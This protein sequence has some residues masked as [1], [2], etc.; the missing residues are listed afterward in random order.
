MP[1]L[2]E[3]E[4]TCR[5]IAPHITGKRVTRVI[6]RNPNLRWPVSSRLGK[7]LS[8]QTINA[9]SRRAKYLLLQTDAGTAIL[10][11]GMSGSL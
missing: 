1:E 9:V 5:G 7:D 6:V 8:G 4:T 2:P 10:H 3:V 11:L